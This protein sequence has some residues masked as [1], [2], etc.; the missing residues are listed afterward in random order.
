MKLKLLLVVAAVSGF[1]L[2]YAQL[3]NDDIL[4]FSAGVLAGTGGALVLSEISDGNRFWTFAGAV[5]GSVLAG[6]I[7]KLLI[8]RIIMAGI[9]GIWELPYWAVLLPGLP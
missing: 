2:S 5:A 7:K 4:H 1:N 8:K 9:T 3:Q 6:S